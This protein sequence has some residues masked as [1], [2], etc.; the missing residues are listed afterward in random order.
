M[1]AR[2]IAWTVLQRGHSIVTSEGERLGSVKEVIGDRDKDIFSGVTY[3]PGL[4]R[5]DLFIPADSISEITDDGLL[6][7]LSQQEADGLDDYEG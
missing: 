5:S 2:Q 1:G 6:L 7:T 4:T 3:S